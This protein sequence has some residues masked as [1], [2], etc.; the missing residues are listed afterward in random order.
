MALDVLHTP[1]PHS[2]DKE[3]CNPA[4]DNKGS[5]NTIAAPINQSSQDNNVPKAKAIPATPVG[6]LTLPDLIGM[7]DAQSAEQDTSPSE[8]VLWNHNI[9][10]LHSSVSSSKA[11]RRKRARSSSPVSSPAQASLNSKSKT[12]AFDLKQFTQ[13][14]KTPQT[15]PGSAL[16]DR[17]AHGAEHLGALPPS[18]QALAQIMYTSSPQSSREGSCAR[19]ARLQRAS[20]CGTQWPKRRKIM[21]TDEPLED[22]VFSDK[23][24]PGPSKL[25]RVNALL[26]KVQGGFTGTAEVAIDG[27]H[28]DSSPVPSG[29]GN[30]LRNSSPTPRECIQLPTNAKACEYETVG[31]T[32]EAEIEPGYNAETELTSSDYGDFDDEEFDESIVDALLPRQNDATYDAC[33][34]H[35]PHRG[36]RYGVAND[37]FPPDNGT[38]KSSGD[39]LKNSVSTDTFVEEDDEF[40]DIDD[41]DLED[42]AARYDSQQPIEVS[43]TSQSLK[44]APTLVVPTAE[45]AQDETDEYEDDMDDMDDIDFEVA[46]TAA[47]QSLQDTIGSHAPVRSIL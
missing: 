27:V 9:A 21:Q 10:G 42:I 11:S 7:V 35:Y 18:I 19:T 3:N 38:T 30:H 47:A 29:S 46:E 25:S 1:V 24:K 14:L 20:S 31:I 43:V 15:E 5:S 45:F 22:D 23:V 32:A 17:Y 6:K 44:M 4:K 2:D 33:P 26:E 40:G 16:W 12:E 13:L 39:K 36:S 41:A 34:K 8:R 28:L 37:I